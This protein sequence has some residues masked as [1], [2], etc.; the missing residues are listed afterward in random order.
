VFSSCSSAQEPFNG[1]SGQDKILVRP[2]SH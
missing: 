2:R 1:I